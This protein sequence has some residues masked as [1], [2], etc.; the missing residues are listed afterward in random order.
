MKNVGLNACGVQEVKL[1][2]MKETNGG[3]IPILI[4]GAALWRLYNGCKEAAASV[5]QES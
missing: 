2:E 1:Q 3:I 5:G 4:L